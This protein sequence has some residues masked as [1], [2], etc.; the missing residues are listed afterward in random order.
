MWEVEGGVAR[1]QAVWAGLLLPSSLWES[2][3]VKSLRVSL[4]PSHN[5]V[6]ALVTHERKPNGR[7]NPPPSECAAVQVVSQAV[8]AAAAGQEPALVNS[9]L[10]TRPR[11][12]CYS[13]LEKIEKVEIKTKKWK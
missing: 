9:S 6:V 7:A 4:F 2:D 13:I 1:G 3:C 12:P 5:K 11:S 8:A 10:G